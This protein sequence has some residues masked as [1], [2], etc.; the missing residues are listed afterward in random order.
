MSMVGSFFMGKTVFFIDGFNLYHALDYLEDAPDHSRYHKYKWISLLKLCSHYLRG[1]DKL[2]KIIYYT[3]LATWDKGKT[4]RHRL[5]IKAQE[6]EGVEI[7]YGRFKEKERK[8]K[9][10]N[11]VYRGREEKETD[12]NIAL[13]LY[14]SAFKDLYDKAVI[15]S[16]D[17]DLLPAIRIIHGTFPGKVI[18]IVVPIGKS[19]EYMK[20]FVDFHFKML[21]KHLS[22]SRFADAL[23][24]KDG[25]ILNCPTS[26][27]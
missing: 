9:L 21:E 27:K 26:W 24:L 23:T 5:F 20:R 7:V 15:V 10:C 3:T 8:C 1:E 22:S 19:S 25:T 14:D 13:G 12:V 17:S 11:R 2:Q 18:G 16:G 4:E 6:N